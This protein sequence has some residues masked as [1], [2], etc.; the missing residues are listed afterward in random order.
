MVYQNMSNAEIRLEIEKLTNKFE[1]KKN[2]IVA[3]CEEMNKIEK[4]YM[5][6]KKEL[7]LRKN[8]FI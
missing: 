8:I 7:D 3:I 6:A 1:A 5:A 2:M 4:E